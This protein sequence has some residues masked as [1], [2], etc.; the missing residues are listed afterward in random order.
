MKTPD[1]IEYF[2]LLTGF[3]LSKLYLSF[4]MPIDLH[5]K[6]IMEYIGLPPIFDEKDFFYNTTTWLYNNG[7]L[8]HS[9]SEAQNEYFN[10][11]V[12][13]S[14]GFAVLNSIPEILN[15]EKSLG[16]IITDGVREGATD[17][18]KKSVRIALSSIF[19]NI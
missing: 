16:D 12:L 4:P 5:Y 2:N 7:Y 13:T 3:I 8:N 9:T 18:V 6:D 1:N 17:S 10:R 11:V 19:Y 14:K 15:Y